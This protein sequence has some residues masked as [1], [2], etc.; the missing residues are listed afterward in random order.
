MAKK[1]ENS[2]P[3]KPSPALTSKERRSF[4]KMAAGSAAALVAGARAAQAQQTQ[5]AMASPPA[6]PADVSDTPAGMITERPGSDFMVDVLKS[7]HF[8]Y[9]WSNPG[10]SF[11]G[12]PESFINYG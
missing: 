8:E 9:L 11:R 12:L 6:E 1:S 10:S 7:L 5:M 4:L 2:S 3:D